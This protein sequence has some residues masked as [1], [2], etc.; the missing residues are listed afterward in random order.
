MVT[1]KNSLPKE[2]SKK[3]LSVVTI[4]EAQ[5]TVD[6]F[7]PHPYLTEDNYDVVQ[8]HVKK[9]KAKLI[10]ALGK[11]FEVEETIQDVSHKPPFS[12]EFKII[13]K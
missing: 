6:S 2:S 5:K 11:E 10:K 8:A 12:F 13:K 3:K 7:A 4:R 1:S 9:I